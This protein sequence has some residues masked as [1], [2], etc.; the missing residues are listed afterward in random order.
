MFSLGGRGGWTGGE[1]VTVQ[2]CGRALVKSKN[3][4]GGVVLARGPGGISLGIMMGQKNQE[5]F[6]NFDAISWHN[7]HKIIFQIEIL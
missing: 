4:P 5:L 6:R 1:K 7:W 2:N 3:Q